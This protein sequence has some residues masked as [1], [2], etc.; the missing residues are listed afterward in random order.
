[1][2]APIDRGDDVAIGNAPAGGGE[3]DMDANPDELRREAED[4]SIFRMGFIA[5]IFIVIGAYLLLLATYIVARISNASALQ[6]V[7]SLVHEAGSANIF[8]L[9][10]AAGAAFGI[11]TLF[12]H[13]SSA[14]RAD[15]DITFK[16]F[17]LQFS[18]PAGPTTLWIACFLTLLVG[19]KVAADIDARK[20]GAIPRTETAVQ[21]PAHR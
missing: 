2:N 12:E 5:I 14:K 9:P 1:M 15:G 20:A 4:A 11:V 10:I 6:T 16:I 13:L 17:G 8:G 21:S 7:I 3:S 18:G 19:I